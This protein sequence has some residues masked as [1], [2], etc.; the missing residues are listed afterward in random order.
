MG[1]QFNVSL[2]SYSYRVQVLTTGKEKTFSEKYLKGTKVHSKIY[3]I[4]REVGIREGVILE[5]Y[6]DVGKGVGWGGG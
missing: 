3:Q 6:K 5:I 1:S 4:R 2:P